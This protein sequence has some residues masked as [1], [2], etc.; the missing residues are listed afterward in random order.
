VLGSPSLAWRSIREPWKYGPA[1]IVAWLPQGVVST[2]PLKAVIRRLVH[3][4]WVPHANLWIAAIDYETGERV[5]FGSKTAPSADLA[6]AV[7]ASCAIP[8]FYYPVTIAGRR[9]VDGGML[10]SA[11]L[12]LMADCDAEI[13]LC[14]N[15]MSSRH[16]GGLLSPSG[17]VAAF[18]RGDNRRLVDREAAGLRELGKRV[19]LLEP[20]REDL[21]VMGFNYMSLR[22]L[23][24]VADTA[25]RTTSRSVRRSELGTLLATLPKGAAARVRRPAGDPS[26]WPAELFPPMLAEV[27]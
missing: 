27:S 21:E 16:R 15:P 8:G 9:Y 19:F 22:K 4:R 24:R 13:V 14:V 17:P 25:L 2:E 23:A 11:N 5:L 1:G 10:S 20:Q 6:D 7:A 3:Q 18:V 12:D 26:T